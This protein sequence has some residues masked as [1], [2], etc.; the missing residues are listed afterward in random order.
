ME[1][2]IDLKN[3][4]EVLKNSNDKYFIEL[5]KLS[6]ASLKTLVE[7]FREAMNQKPHKFTFRLRKATGLCLL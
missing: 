7:S 3:I 4:R 1:N 5:S 2:K 6:D